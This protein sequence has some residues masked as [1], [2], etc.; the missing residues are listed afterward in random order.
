MFDAHLS[1]KELRQERKAERK[2]RRLERK[3]KNLTDTMKICVT[4]PNMGAFIFYVIFIF[5]V[6]LI[7]LAIH[8][9]N[10]IPLYLPLLVP[11]AIVLQK[12]SD[13]KVFTNLYPLD[14]DSKITSQNYIGM[15][16]KMLINFIALAAIL[17]IITTQAQETNSVHGV[18]LGLVY[19]VLIFAVAPVILPLLIDEG[20]ALAKK[21]NLNRDYNWHQ[22][23]TGFLG[24]LAIILIELAFEFSLEAT[25]AK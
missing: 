21:K 7:L 25:L 9:M 18:A 19:I 13:D 15:V 11:L 20:D 17:V 10:L 5:V 14:V 16:S 4:M 3:S 23:T 24:L 22:Y 1:K 12:S 2:Q 6:P 8:K